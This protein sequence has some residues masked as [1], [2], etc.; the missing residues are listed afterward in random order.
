MPT[1]VQQNPQTAS[2]LRT[3]DQTASCS[4][5]ADD[6]GTAVT[7]PAAIGAGT[8]GTLGVVASAWDGLGGGLPAGALLL[9]PGT[10]G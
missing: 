5:G 2:R 10:R 4:V 1:G 8:A 6:P 9:T 7:G 3:S